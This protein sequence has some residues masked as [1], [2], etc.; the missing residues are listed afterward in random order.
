MS[1]INYIN[2]SLEIWGCVMSAIVAL[3]LFLSKHNRD[4]CSRLYLQML[5]LNTGVL[6]FDLLALLFR[7]R[8]GS[9][10][11]WGV[12]ASNFIAFACSYLLMLTFVRYLTEYLS[13]HTEIKRIYL[14]ITRMVCGV[15]LALLVLTQFFPIFYTIDAQNVY[16]RAELF[17]LSQAMGIIGLVLCAVMLIRYRHVIGT[18]ERIV[19]WLYISLPLIALLVQV[20][21]Y[22]LVLLNLANTVSLVVV[23]LFLQA[24]QG[25]LAA[26]RETLLAEKELELSQSRISIMLSQI[27]PHFLYNALATIKHLCA[28]NDPRAEDVVA[29]FAKYLRGNM[30][31]LTNKAPIP[32]DSELK[33]L[34][35]YL[36]IE[37]LRF[38]GVSVVYELSSRDFSLPALT[39]QPMVE[40]AIRYGVTQKQ[41][42][43]GTITVSSWEDEGA[44]YIRIA[45]DGVGFDPMQTQYD[46]RSHI[47]I[48]NT[49]QRLESMCGGEL[50]I[51]SEA[52]LGTTVTIT[53]PK[54]RA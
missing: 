45:D 28:K 38:P 37:R 20:F 11:R 53:L 47:G 7:G 34:E 13:K 12:R 41:G 21:V 44:C 32:F 23:F 22:G 26:E 31:S 48:S 35:N 49:R 6:L 36:A 15:S 30:D 42:S 25:R 5:A 4:L 50:A 40:N 54:E 17:W 16:R 9:L 1:T 39:V 8:P 19:L 24:E 52:G 33:H 46:G 27:Q 18:Q 43:R 3:C 10:C 51:K 2:A 29:S 14:Q